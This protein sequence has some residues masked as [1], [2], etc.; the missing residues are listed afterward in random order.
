MADKDEDFNLIQ[1]SLIQQ[2]KTI[3][4]QYPDDGQI[5]KELIQNAEDANASHV[6][7]LHDKHSYG[8]AHLFDEDLAQFQGPALYAY[9]N[10]RFTKEDWRGIRLVCDS[11]KVEDPMK[12]GRFGLGFKS[13]FHMT[14]LP[15][16]LSDTQIGFIDPHGVH[17]SDKYHRRT[18]K[19]WRL[20]EDRA[21]MDKISDQFLP[22]KEIFDCT[23]EVFS[24][25]FYDGTLFRFP[26]RTEPSDLSGTLYSA[27]KMD[28]LFESFEADAHLVL[29][30]LQHLESIELYVREESQSDPERVFQVK[31]ADKSLQTVRAK[32]KEFRGKITPGKLMTESVTVTYPITIETVK[33]DSLFGDTV[34]QHSFLVTNYFCGAEVSMRF[35]ML[36]TDKELNYL[37]TVGVAMALPTGPKLQTPD[38]KGHVFCFLP[39]PVQKK[40]LTGLPV[41]VNGF[42]ALSQNRRYIKSPNADQEDREMIG[43]QLTDKSLLWNRCLLEEAIPRAYATMI[44]KAINE[45]SFFIPRT[46]IYK[47]WPDTRFIDQ[48]WEK[49]AEPLF[50]FLLK[51][52]V[53]YTHAGDGHWLTVEQVVFD[54]LSENEPKEL[55][56]R[57]L[58][59]AYVPVVSVPSHVM[60]AIACYSAVQNITPS[61]TRAILKRVPSCYKDLNRRDKLLL[62]QFCLKDRKFVELCD[63]EL[64]PLSNGVFTTFSKQGN[65]I[66]ICSRDHPRELFPGVEDR[67][68]DGKIGVEIIE[69][70]KE[71]AEQ[72]VTQLRILCKDD[73]PPLLLQALP[74]E[75]NKGNTVLWYPDDSNHNH[76]PR[77][78][79]EVV[80][81]YLQEHFT[82]A[83]DIL[84]L[85]KLPLIPLSMAQTPVTLTRLCHPSRVVVKRLNDDWLDDE[86]TSVLMKLGL[87]VMNNYPTFLSHHPAVLGTFVNPPTTQGVLRAMVVYSNQMKAGTFSEIVR[88]VLST[89]E[90]HL[91]R[92]FLASVRHVG[93]AEYSLLCCL[94]LLETLSKKFVSKEEGLCAAPDETLPVS[95]QEELID[96]TQQDSKTLALLLGVK[97]LKPTELLCQMVFPDIQRG[98]YSGEQIDKLM[99]YVLDRFANDIRRNAMFK[100][101]LEALPFVSKQRGRARTSDLFDP[102]NVVLKKIFAHEDVFPTAIYTNQ[103]VLVMLQELGMKSEESIDGD[104][105]YRS[106]KVISVLPYHSTTDQ[107]SKAIL[108]FLSDNPEKMREKIKKQPLGVL[109][110]D[111]PWVSRLQERPPNYPP[112]LPWWETHGEEGVRFFKPTEVKSHHFANLIGTVMPVVKMETT[113]QISEY[114]GWQS[115]PSV[116]QVVQH[117]QTVIKSYS[118]DE[119]PFYMVVIKEIYLFLSRAR[120]ADVSFAFECIK[121]FDWVWN[122]DGFSSP[123][124]VLSIK[125]HIDLTPY[126]RSLP[127]DMIK[128]SGLFYRFGMR[129]QSDPAVLVQVLTIIKEKYDDESA[130]FSA[131]EVKHDL[132]LSVNILNELANEQLSDEIQAQIVFPTHIK[133]NSHVR[134][135]PVENCMY[136]EH[137]E[138]LKKEGDDEDMDYFYVHP[139]VPNSTAERL[140]VPTLTNRMLDADELSIGEE[141][142]QEERLTTRLNRLL[143]EYTDGFSVLKELVQNADDAG[144][145]EVRF[146]YDERTNE[147][148]MTCLIDEGM[149]GCQG[150]A[151]WVYN[152]AEFKDEDFENIAKLNEATKVQDTEKIGRFGLGFNAVYNLTDVPMLLSRNYLAIFDPHT[153]YLGKA[154]KS[155]RK[156]G[157]KIDLNKDV[158]RLR[159]FTNQ[160]KPFNGIFGCDLHLDREDNSFDGTLFRF[161]LRTSEQALRSEIKRLAYNDEQMREL[162]LMLVN[163]AKTLLLFTQNVLRV[164]IF[165]LKASA[166]E[167][168]KM[169]LTFQVSKSLSRAGIVRNLSV[170]VTLPETANKLTKED[171]DFLKQ[172]NFLQASSRVTR[173]FR[174]GV[175]TKLITSSMKVDI[176]CSFTEYGWRFF[177]SDL[178]FRQECSTWLVVS[179]M[180]N[181]QALRFVKNDLS[182]LP[183]AGVAVQLIQNG[184]DNCLPLPIVKSDDDGYSVNGILFCYLPL[185]IHSRLPVHVNGAFAL[186]ANR[187]HL[188]EK[189]EDDKK[190]YG[191]DWN[192]VLMQDSISS[193][194]LCLLEDLTSI[195]PSDGRYKFHSLWPKA[196]EIHRNCLPLM[197]SFYAHIASGSYPLFSDGRRW[198]DINQVVF[199]DP[200][201]RNEPIVGD[202]SFNVFQMLMKGSAVVIDVPFDVLRSFLVCGL[203]EVLKPKI[204]NKS[205]F[206]HEV[207]FPKIS[208]VRPELR[209]ALVLHAMDTNWD[210]LVR[211]HACIPASPFGETLKFP[212]QLVHPEKDA[213]QLFLPEDKRFPCG[214]KKSFLDSQRLAKLET[215]GMMSDD[216]PWQEIAER[217]ESIQGLNAANSDAAFKRMKSL[218]QFMEKMKYKDKTSLNKATQRRILEAKFLPVLKKPNAFP[219]P[220]K[221]DEFG[222]KVLLAPKDVFLEEEKYL[223]CCTEPLVGVFIPQGVKALLKLNKKH[224]TLGHVIA[225]L[226]AAISTEVELL[227]ISVHN[228][229]SFLCNAAYFFLQKELV[230]NVEAVKQLLNGKKFILV[231]KMFLF[232]N[233]VALQLKTDCSPYLHKLP[234]SL[235]V[236]FPKLMEVAGVRRHFEEKDYISSLHQMKRF[237][238]DT[239]LD[240]QS[241]QVAVHLADQLGE[242]RRASGLDPSEVQEKWGT[243][244]LP[245]SVGVMRAVPDLCINDCPWMPDE[246]DVLFVNAKIPSLTCYRVG[247]K[248][249]IEEA[250]RDNVVGIPF[251]QSEKLT[252]R[253][254]R[255]L[256]C[257]PCEKE[258]LKELLQNADDAEAT[259]ICFIKDPRHHPDVKV[260]KDKNGKRGWQPLQGPALCV[261]NNKPFTTADINGIRN[262]GEGSKGDDPNKTGQYGVGFNAV[263]H[264]TDAPSFISKGEEIGDV[265]CVFDPHCKFAPGASTQEPGRM[266]KVSTTLQGRFP[267]VF[268]C[269]LGEHFPRDNATMFRFPL[270]TEQMARE[271]KISSTPVSLRKLDTMMEEL[272]K[273]LFEVLLFVNNV[274][275][276][277][278]CEVNG[279]DGNLVNAYTV[280]AAMSKEDE[281][282]RREFADYIKQG[283]REVLPTDIQ[284]ARVSYVLNITDSLGSEEKWLIVQQIGF[285]KPVTMRILNAF[286][287]HQLGMLPRGGVACLL[288]KKNPT[289][290]VQRRKKAYCFLPLPFETGLP[291][292]VNGHFALDHEARRDL[293]R[294]EA[295][296]YRSD[297]NNA[298]L[299]D[300][301]ASCYLTL[302]VEVRG[303]LKLPIGQVANPGTEN[304][305]MQKINVYETFFPRRK[306][307]DQYWKTLVDSVYQE[308]DRKEL[309]ILPVV[310]NRPLDVPKST[311]VV[312]VTWLPPT[313]SGKYQAFFNNLAVTGPF[314][315]SPQKETDENQAKVRK[316]F[317]A[318]LLESGF[319]LV[320]F[321]LALHESFQRAG[322]TTSSISPSSVI[323]FYRT[324]SSQDPCCTIGPIPCSV[325]ETTLKDALGV[326]VVLLYCK[327]DGSFLDKLPGLPLLLT[328]DN[329][330]QLFSSREPKFLPRYHDILPGCPHIFLH[331]QVYRKIFSDMAAVN[332]SVLKPLDAKAFAVNLPQ[333][334]PWDRYG[335]DVF[336]QWSPNQTATPNQR[337]IFRVWVFLH[338]LMK[339][340]LN[341]VKMDE[342]TKN[343]QV[344]TTLEPLSNWSILPVTEAKTA[345]R[346]TSLFPFFQSSTPPLVEHFL[347]PFGQ[348]TSVLEFKNADSSSLKLVDALRKLSL[349]ELNTTAISTAGSGAFSYSSPNSV[350]LARMIVSSLKVPASLLMSLDRKMQSDV[351]SLRGKL[352]P[353][354]CT[355]ILEYFS[356]SVSCLRDA[357]R[358]IL[359]R[360]PFYQATHGGLIRLDDRR[361]CVLPIGIPRKEIDLLER[362]LRVVF[363]ES[364]HG[365]TEL[366]KFLALECVSA[367]DLYCT[368][369]LTNFSILSKEARQIHLEYIRKSILE[370]EEL[371][372][373][374]KQKLLQCLA[375]T[376][377]VPS[378]DGTLK[379]ASCFYDPQ[380]DV[381]RTMLSESLF[382]SKP[383][384]S[385]EW[386]MFLR[387]IGLVHNVTKDH[388]KIFAT[389]V[390]HEAASALSENTCKKSK[391]LVNHLV[392]RHNVVAEGLLQSICDIRFVAGDPVR[393]PLQALCLPFGGVV[394]RQIPFFAFKGAVPTEHAEIVWTKAYLLPRWA[395]PRCCRY[396]LN[397]PARVGMDKYCNTFVAQLQIQE[398]PPI[399]LVVDHCQ[400]ICLQLAKNS[401]QTNAL[402]EQWHTLMA[403]MERIY[404]FL[405]TKPI[406]NSDAKNILE[407]TPCILVEHGK[408]FILPCQAV[409]ELYEHLEIKPFLYGIPKEFGKFHPLFE[410]L[411]CSKCVT[412]F[413][414]AMVLDMLQKRCQ[415]SKLDPNEV[416]ICAKAAKGFFERLE[417][418]FKEVKSLSGLYLPGM[419]LSQSSSER[420]RI[421][422]PLFLHKS[423]D[424][425]FND[426]PPSFR[427]R[428]HNFKQLF[429]LDLRLMDVTCS[430]ANTN[431]KELIM[432][433]PT[434]L[435][436]KM[437]SSVVKEKLSPSQ[438][439][440]TVATQAVT[441]L[442][443]QLSSAQFC[444]GVI[445][446]I[447]DENS[448]QERE[449]DD[450]VIAHIER[451]LRRIELCAVKSI[452]T[453][454][455]SDGLPIPESEAEVPYFLD[456][457][458]VSGE[459]IWRVYLNVVTGMNESTSA[460]WLVSNV[461]D[462]I[463]G[464]LLGSRAVFILEMLRCPLSDIWSLLDSMGVRKDDSHREQGDEIYPDPG[465]FI[466]LEDHH[467]LNDAFEE[468]EAG[469][470]VGYELEDPSLQRRE[471]NATY[472]YAVIIEKVGNEGG[473]PLTKRYRIDIGNG[474][475]TV[476][477]AADLYKFHRL[478]ITTS[479]EIVPSDHQVEPPRN[480]S[481]QEVFDE[482]SDQLEDAWKLPEEKRRKIIKRLYL[483]WHP[484]KNLGNEEFCKEIC[485]HIQNETCRL[486]RGEPRS[487]Q[488]SSAD[489]RT[490]GGAYDDLFSSMGARAREH[491]T[492]RQRYRQRQQS[493]RNSYRTN[494]QPGE[495]RRWFKQ[496]KADVV[497]VENDIVYSNPSY[498]WACFKCHQAAEK[499][500]KAAQYKIDADKTSVHNLVENCN[501]LGD[502]ELTELA[503]QLEILVGDSTRMRYPDRMRFPQIP[504]EVY[505]AEMAQEALQLAKK[506]V[507]RVRHRII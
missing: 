255:I 304:E 91:L 275:K 222:S 301:V 244:Y 20:H 270:R 217:A 77:D 45:K 99:T 133:D 171:Q 403:V 489:T 380:I 148:A 213:A 354:D 377:L 246:P 40:S 69:K 332:T 297:W 334:L 249:R 291:V 410:S 260:F 355:I 363:L 65:R 87:I 162:L 54:Q 50:Q 488:S 285:E 163:G 320:A 216:L 51:K 365:L 253:L 420:I 367:V 479:S 76:P 48:K 10:A 424:L 483:R 443:H 47:A 305:I 287:D 108:Q 179:S 49:V 288:E 262:L 78:W 281:V 52:E 101:H 362:E 17:F 229:I 115:Q 470:Y 24:Q 34:K 136:C 156:P 161:P 326:I 503:W 234:E 408:K 491:H 130:V 186:A 228:E 74:P 437:L 138:W 199:L 462:E 337:W 219:L 343:L 464:G 129:E 432:K 256:T 290:P 192:N 240:E 151:L 243:I 121:E 187:R 371:K 426:A 167:N 318:I 257:Y 224:A 356:K 221:G 11:I 35:K 238:S 269:Y 378:A 248:T 89:N 103:S 493:S 459:E 36:M 110:G 190:C 236:A 448:R 386:L 276:I 457:V 490:R 124:H 407:N 336:V 299:R 56:Q 201:F 306:P 450:G 267:D 88:Q 385:P 30:F 357:D 496:A 227:E 13:V 453:T 68:L 94:P 204:Y 214:T 399:D 497:A 173:A 44:F 263:Y 184:S 60:D 440:E 132:Q 200:E 477:D 366:F 333:T 194:Y 143:E 250:L 53:V 335:N 155:K 153:S 85:G 230:S 232:A 319:N 298:L 203:S 23:G 419:S 361:V 445:R 388:F 381:F 59:A 245:D 486:E 166:S 137:D 422:T 441:H 102:R 353:Q 417:E 358:I 339:D 205:R 1:P 283:G 359:R 454:L 507:D 83:K 38:I 266:I 168:Q 278:L 416:L 233:Q 104:D 14:D 152:D 391:V 444:S 314:A 317:E 231:G 401:E 131:S 174:K 123:S 447:R 397:L 212:S 412:I 446:L 390:A 272:K 81:R 406:A 282:K 414:Y 346:K 330:L 196:S 279:T 374:D 21:E 360:L 405:L 302:L 105:L 431:Y 294:D 251:G 504:N 466:P 122:G 211:T 478:N 452:K 125:P 254:K 71:A 98:R 4:D 31:I 215:L 9:N 383:F 372:D 157:L 345:E 476:V 463:C 261:Y 82:R 344:K 340:V 436:P 439:V 327:G 280:E 415:N 158:K 61:L 341:D 368:F 467:R 498:E 139:H 384:N 80:W 369:I 64:L 438:T 271:S 472:I 170:P 140:G 265:L 144:A 100:R 134:L 404:T 197:K 43:R 127:S 241:L 27:E 66:Y 141:F 42:F 393:E 449:V 235:A 107:K 310:R 146:L 300:V 15:S 295:G 382:P 259:E 389:D 484:D 7:F 423:S 178:P 324:F 195:A 502:S 191:V 277:T 225:Q 411:G 8:K 347:V 482:I 223:L 364:L 237:F 500:L 292:H 120:F 193:A 118:E 149:K 183:S 329:R 469:E 210:D 189:V 392:H 226:E 198:L 505:S 396:D 177:A 409:L 206:F 284:V 96:V 400:K 303:F 273:E 39:L 338:E 97:I 325:N 19:H 321:S 220:W 86:L 176:K 172:C 471:G 455:F 135:E 128:Y 119:K 322:V 70:L 375:S 181:G 451:G 22:Y 202:I 32:R 169:T 394:G 117:L 433:L 147:D 268:P 312:E 37:P 309:Q 296:G 425:I 458:P 252:N 93:P 352:E 429:L 258:I 342:Q 351:Q 311:T 79:I 73:V 239:E 18:G 26:F 113:N 67:F 6:K 286:K 274:K 84:N 481:R 57:V 289:R 2:L 29:L 207:F 160:F 72:E 506:I 435:H 165:S 307:T 185:P 33:F 434:A 188:Q 16:L 315:M 154:I 63:L 112:G 164:S 402:P 116:V 114:F 25:G 126:I 370:D 349:P 242:T 142:G 28:T 3:L 106:A 109:L 145:T 328:Q 218:L 460:M 159:K 395:D 465:S 387:T 92:S 456:K 58:L 413:H 442:K 12:V 209:N 46:S 293:W 475:E 480:R 316:K 350:I 208:T 418:D 247:V 90:K 75:W 398:K 427:N 264:L 323:D 41:H 180:G 313:G 421:V 485:Q 487:S 111:I 55:L 379:T 495:A 428:L 468:F 494:P 5:L 499:A 473:S 62:L 175:S 331:D 501:G 492:Q 150:P 461:L 430:S 95:P 376:P 182:L 308:I 348:A 373:G 474:Q